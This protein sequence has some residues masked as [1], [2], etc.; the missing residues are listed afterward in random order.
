MGDFTPSTVP[1][2]RAPHFWLAD[3]RSL[4]DALRPGY[5]LLRFDPRVDVGA[6]A[7]RAAA[8][9]RRAARA[10]STSPRG[11]APAEYRHALVLV[12]RRPARRLA[13]RRRARPT[14]PR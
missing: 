6:A 11:D 9:A 12:P 3:G 5:T 2:C 7:S 4:Y 1:G 8:R 10:C 13:R 14:P